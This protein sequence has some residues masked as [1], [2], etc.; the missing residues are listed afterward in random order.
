MARSAHLQGM[1]WLPVVEAAVK[2][3]VTNVGAL[4]FRAQERGVSP[5]VVLE[6]FHREAEYWA[7]NPDAEPG[8][9]VVEALPPGLMD[10][11]IFDQSLVWVDVLRI[12]HTISD[13]DDMTDAYLINLIGFLRTYAEHFHSGWVL[14]QPTGKTLMGDPYVWLASTPLMQSLLAEALLRGLEI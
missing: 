2:A 9:D 13:R 6:A 8:L 12:T 4:V 3:G 5:E 11:R 10:P 1:N 7:A 14:T